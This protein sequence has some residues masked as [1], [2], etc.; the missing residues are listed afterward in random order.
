MHKLKVCM[1]Q[2][3]EGWVVRGPA[4]RINQAHEH[5]TL[6]LTNGTIL[7]QEPY[8]D[9]MCPIQETNIT[10]TQ[11]YLGHHRFSDEKFTKD[12]KTEEEGT[13]T[14]FLTTAGVHTLETLHR[15]CIM[16]SITAT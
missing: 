11:R 12:M 3:I 10:E 9:L 13:Q 14:V 7:W 5:H 4:L 2:A 16:Q 8:K 15:M 1:A 6:R